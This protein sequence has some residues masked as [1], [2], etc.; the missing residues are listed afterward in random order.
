MIL[1]RRVKGSSMEP[2]IADGSLVVVAKYLK[3]KLGDIILVEHNNVDYI[4]RLKKIER[5]RVYVSADN[6]MGSDSR[7]WGWL[8]SASIKGRVILR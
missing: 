5:N 7:I 1:I 2:T 8:P 4:K 6:F 3:P